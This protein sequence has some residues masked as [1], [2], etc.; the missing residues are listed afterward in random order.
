M[1]TSLMAS[2]VSPRQPIVAK[3]PI[4]L[5]IAD[6]SPMDCQLLT[7]AFRRARYPMQVVACVVSQS[8]I[9]RSIDCHSPDV[10]LI[11]EGLQDGPHTGF[12]VLREVRDSFPRT[13]VIVLL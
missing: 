11:G 6:H 2:T 3:K 12:G 9:L 8:E 10:A 13:K 5:L 4:A 1:G 7:N